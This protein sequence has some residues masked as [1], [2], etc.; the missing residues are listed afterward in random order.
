MIAGRRRTAWRQSH[1]RDDRGVALVLIALTMVAL[2]IVAALVI[3]IGRTRAR[4]QASQSAADLAVLAAAG[5]L[6]AKDVTAACV[7]TV[8]YLEVN[9]PVLSSIDAASMCSGMAG[10]T[11]NGG[12]TAEAMPSATV[13]GITV[14]VHYPVP[15]SEITSPK[16]VGARLDDGLPCE[17]M[18]VVVTDAQPGFFS[19][20]AGHSVLSATRSA[21]IRVKPGT[22]RKAPALWLLDPT[23]C[24]SLAVSGGAQVTVGDPAV[25]SGLITVDSDGTACNSN[26]VTIS[27]SGSGTK[28]MALGAAD[29][30]T[31]S[32]NAM[33]VGATLCTPPACSSADVSNGRLAPQPG[34]SGKRETRAP[35]TG[36]STAS[37]P[38][39]PITG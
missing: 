15:D 10:T 21:T 6:G 18:R 39:R 32:L 30:G 11:C 36:A 20:M 3:D 7:H 25:A 23:G 28:V 38:T 2:L 9:V 14:S 31:I 19:G 1:R 22:G 13:S 4:A 27:S 35:S 34:A 33:Q 5:D 24:T 8:G 37:R 29:P 17:R 26:Q 16:V 12:M